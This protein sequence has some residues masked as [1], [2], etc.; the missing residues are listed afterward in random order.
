MKK[1]ES[2]TITDADDGVIALCIHPLRQY[3]GVATKM[4]FLKQ[5]FLGGLLLYRSS[6]PTSLLLSSKVA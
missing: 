1:N 2:G 3:K 6:Y 5:K 4:R